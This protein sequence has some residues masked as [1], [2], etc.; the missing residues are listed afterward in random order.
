MTTKPKGKA[1]GNQKVRIMK[2]V[3]VMFDNSD[4]DYTT[5]VSD[6]VTFQDAVDY[7]VGKWFNL[8]KCDQ[9]NMQQCTAIIFE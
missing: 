6:K 7:F 1:Q 2:T 4:F 3:K 5:N 9:D 8:G